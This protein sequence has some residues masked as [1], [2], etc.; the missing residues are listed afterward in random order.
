MASGKKQATQQDETWWEI[1]KKN[2]LLFYCHIM[3][4]GQTHSLIG[5]ISFELKLRN[6]GKWRI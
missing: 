1:E 5:V 6:C 2:R 4:G 3:Y